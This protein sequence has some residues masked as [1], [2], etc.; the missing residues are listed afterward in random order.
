MPSSATITT[1]YTFTANT[2]ARASEVNYNFSNFRGHMIPIDPNTQTSIDNTYDLG[3]SENRWANL[4]AT[5]VRQTNGYFVGATTTS[6]PLLRAQ[7]LTAGALEFLLGS[8]TIAVF[9]ASG[10]SGTYL[11]DDTIQRSKLAS[12]GYVFSANTSGSVTATATS[13]SRTLTAISLTLTTYGRPVCVGFTN[14]YIQLQCLTSTVIPISGVIHIQRA[15]STQFTYN[16]QI[17]NPAG[18][19]TADRIGLGGVN[20]IDNIGATTSAVYTFVL[21]NNGVGTFQNTFIAGAETYAYEI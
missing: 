20:F 2:K 13:E 7:N 14:G 16:F 9:T 15:G 3:S 4:Y 19:G 10:M 17:S 1:F 6:D 11:T 21:V 8:S 5:S 18:P 12:D